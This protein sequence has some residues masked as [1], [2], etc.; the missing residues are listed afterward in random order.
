MDNNG[1]K[2]L[3]NP[4]SLVNPQDIESFNILK[5][6]SATA[7]YGSR[8]SNG[9]IIITTKKGRKGQ[10][11]RVSY[12]GSATVSMKKKTIDVMDGDQYREFVKNLYQGNSRYDDAVGALGD[13]NTN[14][15]DE[16]YRTAFSQDHGV[17]GS[18]FGGE[19]LPYRCVGYT[20]SRVFSR[21]LTSSVPQLL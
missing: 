9:V 5:D 3:S 14:W 16:I 15:Q 18:R 7:I 17:Y 2:G 12:N 20:V 11:V 8:G 1:V 19:I 21:P 10:K 6:A 13:A 4:L